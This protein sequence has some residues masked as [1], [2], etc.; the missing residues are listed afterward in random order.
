[1]RRSTGI[2][3]GKTKQGWA[4]RRWALAL[5]VLVGVGAN[6]VVWLRP[7]GWPPQRARYEYPTYP[8]AVVATGEALYQSTC[9]ACHGAAG[10]GD[11]AADV[12]AL[13]ASMHAWHHA[14]SLFARYVRDGGVYMPAVAPEWND[15]QVAAVTAYIKEW[16]TPRQ[17]AFQ[18]EVSR[19]NP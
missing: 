18:H 17:R 2:S 13:D 3:N 15:E 7:F 1:M 9:S 6:L 5:L 16:W 11:A 4:R 8:A 10:E 14:D 19:N 12:P